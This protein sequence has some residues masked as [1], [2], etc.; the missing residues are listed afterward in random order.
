LPDYKDIEGPVAKLN[1]LSREEA[2]AE[3][4]KCCGSTRWAREV[5]ALKPFWDVTQVL[6]IGH[7]VWSEISEDDWLEAFRA[8]PKIG[9]TKAA[10]K[11]SE[12][13]QRWSEGEQARAQESSDATRAALASANRE[14][15]ERFGFIFIIRASGRTA[16]EILAALR[17]RITNERNAELRVAADE[18]WNITELRL[19]KFLD[20]T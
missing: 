14:Y 16:E 12:Q 8:H 2:Y 9:E 10:A 13:E 4:L 11:V 19:R 20:A 17:A 7:R 1:R 5:A 6:I 18:Q 15:E 3:L